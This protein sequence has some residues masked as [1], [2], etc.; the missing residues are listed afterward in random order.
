MRATPVRTSRPTRRAA[1]I[2]AVVAT[3]LTGCGTEAEIGKRQTSAKSSSLAP[4]AVDTAFCD[5]FS[6]THDPDEL[7]GLLP[8]T[9]QPAID[10]LSAF[11]ALSGALSGDGSSGPDKTSLRAMERAFAADGVADQLASMAAG[12]SASCPDRSVGLLL[13]AFATLASMSG[14][15][16]VG[17]YCE[18]LVSLA[19]LYG[20]ADSSD[21][22]EL[23]KLAPPRH[24]EGVRAL[25]EISELLPTQQPTADLPP[26]GAG[27]LWA[28]G[29]YSELTCGNTEA[30]ATVSVAAGLLLSLLDSTAGAVPGEG[31]PGDG[32]E[33]GD[34]ETTPP[35]PADPSAANA[36]VPPG[37][38][39]SFTVTELP[40]EDDGRFKVSV[41][42]PTGWT[43][44]S[45]MGITFDPPTGGEWGI[46]EKVTVSAGCDGICAPTD[47]QQRLRGPDGYL[48]TFAQGSQVT[49]DRPVSGS[50]GAVIAISK[51]DGDV[52]AVLLR[53]VDT[54]SRYF[55]CEVELT[56]EHAALLNAFVTACESSRPGWIPVA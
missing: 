20:G 11:G 37:A 53:W 14:A 1:L 9:Y 46:F 12:A 22:R 3:L 47:W 42:H 18:R 19:E 49:A 50:A 48:T 21:L 4:L 24:R 6:D 17:P 36:A 2:T 13:G 32:A 39:L 33:G 56:G 34:A 23:E 52:K 31:G 30:F 44:D 15:D 5:A 43:S 7:R 35:T 27:A 55:R 10:A 45:F 51:P 26:R 38:T 41:V 54:A 8:D 28:L 25:V 16:K 29:L 40:T